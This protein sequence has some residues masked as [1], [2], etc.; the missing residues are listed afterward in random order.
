ML[1]SSGVIPI[2]ILRL[3][4][5]KLFTYNLHIFV[6]RLPPFLYPLETSCIAQKHSITHGSI[7]VGPRFTSN[8]IVSR[9]S[10]IL[11]DKVFR[12]AFTVQAADLKPPRADCPFFPSRLRPQTGFRPLV[13][14]GKKSSPTAFKIDHVFRNLLDLGMGPATFVRIV[15][16]L[17]QSYIICNPYYGSIAK[18]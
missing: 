6:G 4:F 11:L 1:L 8:L 16:V 2:F 18:K 13:R 5:A 9:C 10:M 12:Q 14:P 17:L 3:L 7:A 15:G